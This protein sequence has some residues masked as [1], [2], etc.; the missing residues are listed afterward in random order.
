MVTSGRAFDSVMQNGDYLQ[1]DFL[2]LIKNIKEQIIR[3]HIKI[4][5]HNHSFPSV[6]AQ[7]CTRD[8]KSTVFLSRCKCKQQLDGPLPAAQVPR[9]LL[10]ICCA[11]LSPHPNSHR[12]PLLHQSQ[13]AGKYLRWPQNGQVSSKPLGRFSRIWNTNL[14]SALVTP[15]LP[16][17]WWMSKI[18][19]K[20]GVMTYAISWLYLASFNF[21]A[22]RQVFDIQG[23]CAIRSPI[24]SLRIWAWAAAISAK[25][26]RWT[27]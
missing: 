24:H 4:E 5:L 3:H 27:F 25:R 15:W 23:T 17:S 19:K 18:Q 8:C 11:L 6:I 26:L 20:K 10:G 7:E 2:N 22:G 14:S 1:N 21:I 9:Q 16:L 13:A 12:H